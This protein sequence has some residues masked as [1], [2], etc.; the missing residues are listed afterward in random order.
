MKEYWYII[1]GAL[2]LIFLGILIYSKD[3]RYFFFF[4][5]GAITGFYFDIVSVSQGYY[6]YYPFDLVILGVPLSVT[7]AEGCAI[8]ITIFAYEH[9]IKNILKFISERLV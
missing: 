4:I 1:S 2:I 6:T 3:K 9:I 8:A 7:I 5:T